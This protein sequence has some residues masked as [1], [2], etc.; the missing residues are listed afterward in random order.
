[1]TQFVIYIA[2]C[3]AN[4]ILVQLI[5]YTI[6]SDQLRFDFLAQNFTPEQ[7][8]LIVVNSKIWGWVGY[9]TIPILVAF[10][11]AAITFCLSLGHLYFFSRLEYKKILNAVLRSE[12]IFLAPLALKLFWFNFIEEDFAPIDFQTFS[13]LSVTVFYEAHALSSWIIYPMQT[14]NL[15][16]LCYVFYLSVRIKKEMAVSFWD[17]LKIVLIPY[18][19]LLVFW[20]AIAT[21][22]TISLFP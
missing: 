1:M 15:F 6:L 4:I 20:L 11:V 9:A 7:I 12:F 3:A 14:I 5:N 19:T 18:L 10:K 8:R 22:L 21:Y 2:L 16:E 13:P 17:S